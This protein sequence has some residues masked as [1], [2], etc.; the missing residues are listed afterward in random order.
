VTT[1]FAVDSEFI[2]KHFT[3]FDSTG[4]LMVVL[5]KFN[6]VR[7]HELPIQIEYEYSSFRLLQKPIVASAAIFLLFVVSIGLNKLTFTIGKTQVR[8]WLVFYSFF[9]LIL[10][11]CY[12]Q[13]QA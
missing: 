3:Y 2:D 8:Q 1:P 4:R 7:E 9:L 12:R 13:S 5:E 6:V 11:L 10:L